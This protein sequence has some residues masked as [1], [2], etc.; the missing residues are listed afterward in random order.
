[1]EPGPLFTLLLSVAVA[2]S[3]VW[4]IIRA[5]RERKRAERERKHTAHC[6]NAGINRAEQI[7]NGG[8]GSM[9]D[10]PTF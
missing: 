3:V 1:M 4:L 10:N 5:K 7:N 2:I 8:L 9:G 6:P